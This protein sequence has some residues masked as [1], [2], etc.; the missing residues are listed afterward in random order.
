MAVAD[1]GSGHLRRGRRCSP[2]SR[3]AGKK[4]VR[5]ESP[6]RPSALLR[7]GVGFER[8][9]AFLLVGSDSM[10]YVRPLNREGRIFYFKNFQKYTSN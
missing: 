6:S 10:G 4:K 9:T 3:K 1:R 8:T 7:F 2:R 5:G